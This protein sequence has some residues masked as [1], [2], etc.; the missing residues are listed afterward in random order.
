MEGLRD[1][2]GGG[3]AGPQPGVCRAQNTEG[4]PQGW[5][6][7][8]QESR[9]REH[10]TLTALE[11]PESCGEPHPAGSVGP[12]PGPDSD[13]AHL[14]EEKLLTK[15]RGKR[16]APVKTLLSGNGALGGMRHSTLFVPL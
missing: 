13:S 10:D 2:V 11:W 12:L 8:A 14:Q 3:R 4:S 6:C 5:G 9:E 15:A 1:P 16:R 7:P